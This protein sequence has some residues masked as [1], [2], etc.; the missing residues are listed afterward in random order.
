MGAGRHA[1]STTAGSIAATP[2]D[3]T[4]MHWQHGSSMPRSE[5]A[6]LHPVA[7][8]RP[9][10]TEP[11]MSSRVQDR[12]SGPRHRATALE[13]PESWVPTAMQ[14]VAVGQLLQMCRR[15]R[16]S[17]RSSRPSVTYMLLRLEKLPTTDCGTTPN[18]S[19][20]RIQNQMRPSPDPLSGTL[21]LN[22]Q[23][24]PSPTSA[25]TAK[26]YGRPGSDGN[27]KGLGRAGGITHRRD[28][29]ESERPSAG[30]V[31]K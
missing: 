6:A 18:V 14:S 17:P 21:F 13:K 10:T 27:A 5:H 8:N 16:R 1:V 19:L 28:P 29:R 24:S 11:L 12:G 4:A 7:R 31:D 3:P 26:P 20:L 23:K 15:Q 22:S 9:L 30:I 2:R 25:T